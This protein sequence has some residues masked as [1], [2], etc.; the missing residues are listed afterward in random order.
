[1]IGMND[2]YYSELLPMTKIIGCLKNTPKTRPR[3]KF[4]SLAW[5][6]F[7]DS[8][9]IKGITWENKFVR[10]LNRIFFRWEFA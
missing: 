7:K 3:I 10:S 5:N 9:L 8:M 2:E 6:L 4:P 1:M